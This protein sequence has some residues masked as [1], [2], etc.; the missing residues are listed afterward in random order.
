MALPFVETLVPYA[1]FILLVG[2]VMH[3]WGMYQKHW[4]ETRDSTYRIWWVEVLYWSCWAALGGSVL[5][6]AIAAA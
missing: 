6:I 3:G 2:I 1:G 5:I 4:L